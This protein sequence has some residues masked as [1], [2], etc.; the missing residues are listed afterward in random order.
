MSRAVIILRNDEQRQ[1][2]SRW[3][4]SAPENAT[5]TFA[6]PK[7]SL[8]QNALMWALLTD[9]ADQLPWH[10]LKLSAED[11]KDLLTAGLKRELRTVPNTDGNGF[12]MLG[13]RTSDMSVPEMA[14]FVEFILAFGALHGVTFT[15]Q[16]GEPNAG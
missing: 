5:V 8:E 3:C 1:R 15:S 2:A 10:G 7:R 6:K 12:V 4:F 14:N 9:L 11:Y 13:A 16:S